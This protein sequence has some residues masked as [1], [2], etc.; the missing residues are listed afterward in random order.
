MKIS[1]I[2]LGWFG[3]DLAYELKKEGHIVGGTTTSSA[4]K[5]ILKQKGINAHLLSYP[6]IPPT[7]LLEVDCIIL[8]IPPFQEELN[9]FQS[10]NFKKD[11][12]MIFIS[13]ISG[14]LVQQEEWVKN[15]FSQWTIL[16]FG[17]LYGKQRHP[18]KNLSGRQNLPGRKWPVNLLH[19]S[20]AIGFTKKV[21]ELNLQSQLFHVLSGEHPS[22]EEFYH[23][24]CQ[25]KGLPMPHFD[26]TDQSQKE[27]VS[28]QDSEIYYHFQKLFF[29]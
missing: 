28:N 25:Q 8:N 14:A 24:Y 18:G 7:E 17:G 29:D 21:I 22:R 15:T 23:E 26:Q 2:G 6:S 9:W 5:E 20:D 10:W 16:R 4:K 3:E 19:L 1:V 12:W 27:P 13:T 11:T